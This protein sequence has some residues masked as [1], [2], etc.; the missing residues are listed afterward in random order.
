MKTRSARILLLT[1]ALWTMPA[2]MLLADNHNKKLPVPSEAA[3]AEAMKVIKEV[4]GTEYAKAESLAAKQALGR[5]LLEK[6][7]D[8]HDDLAGRFVLLKLSRDISTQGL[9]GLAAFQAVDTMAETFEIDPV[10]M[11]AAVLKFG[12]T[13]AKLKQHHMP[14][15]QT[16]LSLVDTAIAEDNYAVAKQLCEFAASE[17][18]LANEPEASSLAL[19]RSAEVEDVLAVLYEKAQTATAMLRAEPVNPEANAAMGKYLCS[20]KGDWD[21]GVLMLALG[22]DTSLKALAENE[23]DEL[24]PKRP[25]QLGDAWWE[26]AEKETGTIQK[27]TQARAA[28]W[29]REALPGLS[30]LA[31]DRI[32]KRLDSLAERQAT[33][34]I[35][36]NEP[37]APVRASLPEHTSWTVPFA[38]TEQV[39]RTRTV[40]VVTPN[41][42]HFDRQEP[43]TATVRHRGSK[44]VNAKLVNYDCKTG[45]VVLKSIP[46]KEKGEK[47]EV[48]SFRYAALGEDDKKYL[49]AV[50]EQLTK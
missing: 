37:T 35:V 4:F 21:R 34:T 36:Q 18:S 3:Q 20:V 48:R 8:T 50:K 29:Y 22:N 13:H 24:T 31:R 11:K 7:R 28:Y 44:T 23:L 26:R 27:Q 41:G 32:L 10:E 45:T 1:V 16:A 6:A 15:M 38:W 42:G 46:D 14:L 39:Q 30:G 33:S 49:T 2:R 43:Y 5:K 47:E 12:A 40:T 19:R 9:D 25:V 17:A